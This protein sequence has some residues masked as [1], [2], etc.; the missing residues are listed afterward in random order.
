MAEIARM[1]VALG[2][3]FDSKGIDKGMTRLEKFK[4]RV[5]AVRTGLKNLAI[6]GTAIGTA[7]VV[8]GLKATKVAGVQEKAERRLAQAMA[9][10]GIFTEE[11][12]QKNLDYADKEKVAKIMKIAQK[13]KDM[14]AFI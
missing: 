10:R 7:L 2:S 4:Q 13:I 9:Q 3:K 6:A 14:S 12:F 5:K 11:A 1:F 8:A